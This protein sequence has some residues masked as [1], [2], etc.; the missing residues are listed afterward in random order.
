MCRWQLDT[1]TSRKMD[2]EKF[3]KLMDE[4]HQSQQKVEQELSALIS[5]LK[6]EVTSIQEKMSQKLAQRISKSLQLQ[7]QWKGH[8]R[9]FNST[10]ASRNQLHLQEMSWQN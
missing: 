1:H 2:D 9:Q 10:P 4:I 7:F 8:E 5:D 3:Q 6:R